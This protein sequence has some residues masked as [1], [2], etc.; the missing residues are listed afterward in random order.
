MVF[1]FSSSSLNCATRYYAYCRHAFNGIIQAGR[2][3]GREG[4]LQLTFCTLSTTISKS[5]GGQKNTANKFGDENM[6]S[7]NLQILASIS[8]G[9]ADSEKGTDYI[10]HNSIMELLKLLHLLPFKIFL[11]PGNSNFLL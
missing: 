11:L 1:C 9:A 8:S 3:G 10:A 4:D 5:A 7:K 6:N 2:Q